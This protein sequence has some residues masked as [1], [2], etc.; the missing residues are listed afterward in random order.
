MDSSHSSDSSEDIKARSTDRFQKQKRAA[1]IAPVKMSKRLDKALNQTK[2]RNIEA[3]K[4]AVKYDLTEGLYERLQA[5]ALEEDIDQIVQRDFDLYGPYDVP[6]DE[7]SSYSEDEYEY[8]DKNKDRDDSSDSDYRPFSQELSDSG[9]FFDGR[10]N[11]Q[12][13]SYSSFSESESSEED[14]QA[15]P[16]DL[17]D[18]KDARKD[19][20]HKNHL[21]H[22]KDKHDLV[23]KKVLT[24][25][26]SGLPK[27]GG[28]HSRTIYNIG[29]LEKH[30]LAAYKEARH[31]AEVAEQP[32]ER[33][34]DI[35]KRCKK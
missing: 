31:P 29:R 27:R 35:N 11:D 16:Y 19:K 8:G 18:E 20:S 33:A 1:K 25:A 28:H 5:L 10:Y 4:D 12:S 14:L 30:S 7:S 6:S 9:E 17:R 15:E 32:K 23:D 34:Q 22:Q 13:D 24:F 26:F 3:K 2:Q 21:S